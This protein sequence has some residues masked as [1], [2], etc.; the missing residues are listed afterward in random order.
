[1]GRLILNAVGT[2]LHKEGETVD[3][4]LHALSLEREGD[5]YV[6]AQRR[7]REKCASLVNNKRENVDLIWYDRYL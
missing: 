2:V 5:V 1:M 3:C 4:K 7:P 6:L